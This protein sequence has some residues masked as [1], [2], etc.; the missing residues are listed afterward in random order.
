MGLEITCPECGAETLVRKEPMYDGFKKTG[1]RIFC[2]SCGHEFPDESS[3]PYKERKA[4]CVFDESDKP[5]K[6]DIFDEEEK[7]RNCRHCEHYI[8]NPFVQRCA[9]TQKEVEA[10]DVCFDFKMKEDENPPEEEDS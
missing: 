8:V 6:L 9:L 2:T 3:I 10:T 1:E 5:K 4:L 7:V